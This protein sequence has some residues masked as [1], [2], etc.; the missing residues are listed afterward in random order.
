MLTLFR[1]KKYLLISHKEILLYYLKPREQI[2]NIWPKK[3]I[4][5]LLR[6]IVGRKDIW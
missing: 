6:E 4:P 1:L 5:R 3:K 2:N